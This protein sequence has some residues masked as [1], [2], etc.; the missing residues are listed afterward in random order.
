[1]S[2]NTLAPIVLKIIFST[3]PQEAAP[4]VASHNS[5]SFLKIPAS[6]VIIVN[7][8]ELK[9]PGITSISTNADTVKLMKLALE[10]SVFHVPPINSQLN[11]LT[12]VFQEKAVI[13][14]MLLL[15][16]FTSH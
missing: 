6:T 1:M 15:Q 5:Q 2:L 13:F 10:T 8:K 11:N 12:V 7:L 3:K 9:N 16:R 4:D 14:P